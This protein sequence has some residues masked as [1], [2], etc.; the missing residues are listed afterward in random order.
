MMQ[1]RPDDTTNSDGAGGQDRS[2]RAGA[3]DDL[4]A[5]P[6]RFWAASADLDQIAPPPLGEMPPALERLGPIPLGG[7]GFPLMGFF[8]T[9]YDHVAGP[10]RDESSD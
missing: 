1:A 10:F 8:A 3:P 2:V 5:E 7:G 4:P 9:V 6:D